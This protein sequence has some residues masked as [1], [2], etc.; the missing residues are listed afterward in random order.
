MTLQEIYE[1]LQALGFPVSYSHFAE[2]ETPKCPFAIY[3]VNGT[4][5]FS[6][7]G[8]VYLPVNEIDIVLYTEEKDPESEKKIETW[9]RGKGIFYNKNE[10]FIESEKFYEITYEMEEI[11]HEG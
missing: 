3:R 7:D 6:A 10:E 1:G 11:E 2:G 4:N 8:M 9:L 5:N